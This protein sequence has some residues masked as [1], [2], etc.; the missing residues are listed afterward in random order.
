MPVSQRA[1]KFTTP[2]AAGKA[3][4]RAR[5]HGPTNTCRGILRD[6][7]LKTFW[8]WHDEQLPDGTVIWRS[9]AGQTY[10]THPGSALLFPSL[11]TPTG[12]PTPPDK[13]ATDHSADRTRKMPNR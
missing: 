9:P 3:L 13:P 8:G 7:L 1:S 10:I 6:H 4:F 12:E 11:S 5:I 2:P